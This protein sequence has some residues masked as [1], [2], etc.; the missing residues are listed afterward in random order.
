MTGKSCMICGCYSSMP[1]CPSCKDKAYEYFDKIC[2]Y[3][4]GCP[5]P[6]VATTYMETKVPLQVIYGLRDI[7][8]VDIIPS[9]GQI[10]IGNGKFLSKSSS[11]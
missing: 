10:I 7:G 1:F 4:K 11:E 8:L 2:G 6:T 9:S 5:L 3:I